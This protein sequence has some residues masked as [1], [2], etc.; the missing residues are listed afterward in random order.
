MSETKAEYV[1]SDKIADFV[2][3]V[4]EWKKIANWEEWDTSC[5]SHS[6]Y[7]GKYWR[8]CPFCG[9]LIKVTP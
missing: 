7:L 3:T 2:V 6:D 5:D 4:C 1:V 9:K 8:F